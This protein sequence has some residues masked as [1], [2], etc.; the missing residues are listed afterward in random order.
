MIS[1]E[2]DNLLQIMP[3]CDVKS[4]AMYFTSVRA[5]CSGIAGGNVTLGVDLSQDHILILFDQLL[6]ANCVKE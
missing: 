6:G 3:P 4:S 1:P 5:G 2:S